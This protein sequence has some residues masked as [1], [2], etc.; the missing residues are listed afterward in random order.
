MRK[1]ITIIIAFA[2]IGLS[3]GAQAPNWAWAKGATGPQAE[4]GIAIALDSAGDEYITGYFQGDSIIFGNTTLH[5]HTNGFADIFLAK[6]N[7]SGT[8]LWAKS[9]GGNSNDEGLAI[10]LDPL[11][12]VYL[13]GLIFNDTI[14]FGNTT[15]HA[16]A[17]SFTAFNV[18]LDANGNVIWAKSSS[19]GLGMGYGISADSSGNSYL[20]GR[21]YSDSITFG[22]ITLHNPSTPHDVE[23]LV[24]FDSSGNV[25]W[26]KQS[27]GIQSSGYATNVNADL[28]GNIYVVGY[29]GSD[30]ISFGSYTLHNNGTFN[31][32]L[33]KYDSTGNVLWAKSFGGTSQDLSFSVTNDRFGNCFITGYNY[34]PSITFDTITLTGEFFLV[35]FNSNGNVIW[36]KTANGKGYTVATDSVGSSYA[37]GYLDSTITF[38]TITLIIPHSSVADNMFIVKY[39]SSGH[40]VFATAIAGGG[41]D[42]GGIAVSHSSVYIGEDFMHSP[43]IVGPDTLTNTGIEDIF[44]AKLVFPNPQEGI[45]NLKQ[46]QDISLYPNPTTALLTLSLPNTSQKAII[47]LYNMLGEKVQPQL[48]TNNSSLIIDLSNLSQGIYFLEVLMDGEKQVRKVVK[49]N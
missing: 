7:P 11:G 18:K 33:L 25:V 8:L 48:I 22:T 34:S 29:F 40:A 28:Y 3:A 43:F 31:I 12:N 2:L 39:D 15:L 32:F 1:I 24:K 37:T 27:E 13:A 35:K 36:A 26:A 46:L 38:D 23:F 9:F 16:A 4:E 19:N 6:Y 45:P 47:N 17:S 42:Y 44:V 41:D 10:S 20:A 49:I 14:I 5:N 21:Y 30:S